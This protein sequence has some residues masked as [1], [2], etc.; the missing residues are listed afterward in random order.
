MPPL[1]IYSDKPAETPE[2]DTAKAMAEKVAAP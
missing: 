2:T 1:N